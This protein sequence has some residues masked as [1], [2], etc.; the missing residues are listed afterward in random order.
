[1]I[2][3]VAAGLPHRPPFV[4]IEEIVELQP[5]RHAK[6]TKFFAASEPFF[7]GHFPGNPLVPGV[8]LTEAMAQAAGVA[9]GQPGRA[10]RLSAIKLMKFLKPVLPGSSVTF[11][12]EKAAEIGGLWQFHTKASVGDEVVAEG[13]IVLAAA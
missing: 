3:P 9:A 7:A 11:T 6:C 4:F 1:M 2:D 10:F 12:A 13:V 8:I 5:G